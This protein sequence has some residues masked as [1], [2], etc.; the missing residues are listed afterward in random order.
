MGAINF[1]LNL[2]NIQTI[3]KTTTKDMFELPDLVASNGGTSS[4][5]SPIPMP[6]PACT[7]S[8]S[9]QLF[10]SSNFI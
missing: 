2:S 9:N 10:C 8:P 1:L 5:S 4:S 7:K 6:T 3:S